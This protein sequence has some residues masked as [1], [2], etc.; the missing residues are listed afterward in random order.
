MALLALIAIGVR[1]ADGNAMRVRFLKAAPD[2]IPADAELTRYARSRGESAYQ[3][4]CAACHGAK[5]QGDHLRNIPNLS[6]NSWLYGSGRV[7]EIERIVMYGI[8]SGNSKGWDLASM[9]AYATR[10]PYKRYKILPLLPRE[11]EDVTAFVLAFQKPPADAAAV[12]RGAQVFRGAEK[13]VCWD[14]H[15]E[16]AR[17]D[18]AIGAPDLTDNSWLSGDG[19]AQSIHD[20][21]AFGLAGSCPAWMSRLSPATIRVLAVYVHSISEHAPATASVPPANE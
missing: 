11:I 13:G 4:H 21:I 7:S 9:P 2:S 3:E 18:T 17:G 19:S 15:G 16:D 6:D 8:R 14:C 5:F 20:S 10:E 1:I 12:E